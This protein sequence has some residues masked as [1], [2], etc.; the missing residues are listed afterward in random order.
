MR[1]YLS[2]VGSRKLTS[3]LWSL[4][5][6]CRPLPTLLHSEPKPCRLLKFSCGSIGHTPLTRERG[7]TPLCPLLSQMKGSGTCV[8]VI[9][10]RLMSCFHSQVFQR[11]AEIFIPV[12][13]SAL[14]CRRWLHH[15]RV[16]RARCSGPLQRIALFGHL[17]EHLPP[18]MDHQ[19][20]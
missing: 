8:F 16:R 18:Y 1:G 15:R 6:H 20:S 17:Q 3:G 9:A 14:L 11:S 5:D 13:G 7:S 19:P 2:A 10:A 12:V 4:L